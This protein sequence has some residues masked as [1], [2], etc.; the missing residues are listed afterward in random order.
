MERSPEIEQLVRDWFA[1]AS[2]GEASVVDRYVTAEPAVRLVG[3]DPGEWIQGGDR[4]ADFLR[5]EVSGAGGEVTFTPSET[6]GYRDGNV[7]WAATNL[8]ITLSDGKRVKPRW[9]AVLVQQD[10]WKFVQTHAS[11]GVPNDAVGWSY[12]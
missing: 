8:T 3:S 1:A 7:A 9:T 10:G 6:E 12:D 11:I 4:V 5:G 2:R